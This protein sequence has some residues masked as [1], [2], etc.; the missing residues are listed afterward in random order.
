MA[1]ASKS[2]L[3]FSFERVRFFPFGL[4]PDD[5]GD[6]SVDLFAPASKFWA[7]GR[8]VNESTGERFCS[9]SDA[10]LFA[11]ADLEDGRCD[12]CRCDNSV[13]H[14]LEVNSSI[15]STADPLEAA[16]RLKAD[17]T[18]EAFVASF[19]ETPKD[20]IVLNIYM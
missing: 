7:D 1:F 16:A 13:R 4:S 11:E 17:D 3:D 6:L 19:I 12:S 9:K 5:F 18:V 15:A 10:L 2:V 20:A 8:V 14:S